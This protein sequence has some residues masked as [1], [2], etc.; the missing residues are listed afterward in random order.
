MATPRGRIDEEEDRYWAEESDRRTAEHAAMMRRNCANMV[1]E[2]QKK[3]GVTLQYAL[4]EEDKRWETDEKKQWVAAG[5]EALWEAVNVERKRWRV[6]MRSLYNTLREEQ[7]LA[8]INAT[9]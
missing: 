2:G 7:L 8:A 3:L 1:N 9:H 5:K 4:D 6:S